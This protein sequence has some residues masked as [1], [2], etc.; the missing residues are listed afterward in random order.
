MGKLELSLVIQKYVLQKNNLDEVIIVHR[1]KGI[2]A[3]GTK[4]IL[5][6]SCFKIAAVL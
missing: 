6:S 3:L 5:F 2:N 1:K 4:Y